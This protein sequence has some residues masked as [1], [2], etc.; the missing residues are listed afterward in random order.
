MRDSRA[1]EKRKKGGAESLR[2]ALC[3]FLA[4]SHRLE[5]QCSSYRIA[6]PS[7]RPIEKR[8]LTL[9]SSIALTVDCL[10]IVFLYHPYTHPDGGYISIPLHADRHRPYRRAPPLTA[11][12]NRASLPSAPARLSVEVTSSAVRIDCA[13]RCISIPRETR[14]PASSP[15]CLP[16]SHT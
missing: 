15:P 9:A 8:F 14:G 12:A 2:S 11:S 1:C 7:W 4:A 10:T 5:F 16:E 6:P 13:A 3:R